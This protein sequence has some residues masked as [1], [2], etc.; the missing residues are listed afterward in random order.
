MLNALHFQLRYSNEDWEEALVE[1]LLRFAKTSA[2]EIGEA[3]R[4]LDQKHS[5]ELRWNRKN[6]GDVG[7]VYPDICNYR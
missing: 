4:F 3:V 6:R 2:P 7:G 5:Q 1:H